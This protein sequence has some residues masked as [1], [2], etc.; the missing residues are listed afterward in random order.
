[1]PCALAT[2]GRGS[3][4]RKAVLG[5]SL[6]RLWALIVTGPRIK[7]CICFVFRSM[8]G[9]IML[10][11]YQW[12]GDLCARIIADNVLAF[13]FSAADI[14]SVPPVRLYLIVVPESDSPL[15]TRRERGRWGEQLYCKH[16]PHLYPLRPHTAP[17]LRNGNDRLGGL[18]TRS[19]RP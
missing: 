3:R 11:S 12:P 9:Q 4:V 14:V 8:W 5:M 16:T 19:T 7:P 13:R 10:G 15:E 2:H 18:S 17:P 1:M 6:G